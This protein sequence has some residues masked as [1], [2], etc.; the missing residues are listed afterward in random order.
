[1]E[2]KYIYVIQC[3]FGNKFFSENEKKKKKKKK[4]TKNKQNQ[5]TKE[6]IEENK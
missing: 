3:N 1:M 2:R 6:P 4:H 5:N